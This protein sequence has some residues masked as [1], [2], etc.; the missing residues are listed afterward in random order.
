MIQ[1]KSE[2]TFLF[3]TIMHDEIAQVGKPSDMM[4][5]SSSQYMDSR[6][7]CGQKSSAYWYYTTASFS[8][9]GKFSYTPKG[10]LTH[11]IVQFKVFDEKNHQS[12]DAHNKISSPAE[13][14]V[15]R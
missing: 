7:H 9:K 10:L 1:K 13:M 15:Y 4:D 11:R 14:K 8:W 5:E 3:K 2:V 6:W 12:D